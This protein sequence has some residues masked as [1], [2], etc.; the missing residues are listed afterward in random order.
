MTAVFDY[1]AISLFRRDYN[2]YIFTSMR[3]RMIQ[4]TKYNLYI[5]T[6]DSTKVFNSYLNLTLK[7]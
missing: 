3:D 2:H 5:D 7:L 6:S 1:H 4:V